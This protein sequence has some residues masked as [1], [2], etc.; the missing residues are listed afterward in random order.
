MTNQ[1]YESKFHPEYFD[2][3]DHVADKMTNTEFAMFYELF[4]HVIDTL[5][6]DPYSNS[7]ECQYGILH[8]KGF[9]TMTFHSK[10]PKIHTGDMR[11]IFK[12]DENT[13]T[14]YYFAVGKRINT[15][16]RPPEDIYSKAESLLKAR[17]EYT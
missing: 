12:I 6:K 7:R 13:K 2:T 5:E 3:F 10:L 1:T 14:N 11:V 15:R 16:P 9:R 17:G 4:Q 8:E